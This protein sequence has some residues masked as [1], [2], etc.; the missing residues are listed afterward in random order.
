MCI[1]EQN[2][3]LYIYIEMLGHHETKLKVIIFH[4]LLNLENPISV[5]GI[6]FQ[7]RHRL[8]HTCTASQVSVGQ[9]I[10][11]EYT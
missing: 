5:E 1:T 9:S 6:R 3:Y 4:C 8:T 11:E 7:N 10:A 2:L